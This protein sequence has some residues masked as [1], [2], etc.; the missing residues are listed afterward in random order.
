[1]SIR[2]S[3]DEKYQS[4]REQ[5][6]RSARIVA[7]WPPWMIDQV[8]RRRF[9][10]EQAKEDLSKTEQ[11]S[12]LKMEQ[13]KSYEELLVEIQNLTEDL[14]KTRDQLGY[15]RTCNQKNY[16]LY[17]E[18]KKKYEDVSW[19]KSWIDNAESRINLLIQK[20]IDVRDTQIKDF[21]KYA[22]KCL[23]EKLVAIEQKKIAESN[24]L[25]YRQEQER[26][27]NRFKFLKRENKRL[28]EAFEI[29]KIEFGKLSNADGKDQK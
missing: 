11:K 7:Q 16:D 28:K 6:E 21:E 3:S 8:E 13:K 17:L 5:M 22:E 9:L 27:N 14:E 15:V 10:A 12:Q 23:Q 29:L 18:F 20:G 4:L 2:M 19:V 1:M 26:K 25:F 24:L